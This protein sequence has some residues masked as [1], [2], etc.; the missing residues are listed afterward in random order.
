MLVQ[1]HKSHA[2]SSANMNDDI[3][4][5]P[6]GIDELIKKLDLSRPIVIQ[7]HDFPDHDAVASGFGLHVLLMN[8]GVKN[9]LCYSGKIQS[10]S[11]SEAIRRLEIP[12]FSSTALRLSNSGQIILV[13]GFVGN[14]NVSNI[15]GEVVALIDHHIPPVR[16]DLAYWDIRMGYGSCS[17]II[18]SY[19][20]QAKMEIPPHCATSLLMGLMMDTA[21][22]TRG[23]SEVDLEAFSDLFF[24]GDWSLG[25]HLLKN[26][27]SLADLRFFDAALKSFQ[28]H[29]DFCF[30]SIEQDC[31]PELAA[32]IADFFL[33]LREIEFVVVLVP[34]IDEYRLSVRSSDRRK[35]ADLV[36][37]RALDEIGSGG[38][39]MHMGG[40]Q[41]L[42][43]RFPGEQILRNRFIEA[44]NHVQAT[45]RM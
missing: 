18:H 34:S 30:I 19:F 6:L 21:F 20:V 45:H 35:P 26:S 1:K 39:H 42:R 29:L 31:S 8:R 2:G 38:G 37:R 27:L 11:L 10:A 43:D 15:P 32:L 4:R 16:P 22:M 14:R 12:I 36:I 13:D 7:A 41:V 5:N 28:V 40:G 24:K 17:T 25:S 44:I 23:V 3:D 9:T 33:N